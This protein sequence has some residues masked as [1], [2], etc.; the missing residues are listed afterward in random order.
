MYVERF[1]AANPD[2]REELNGRSG[3]GESGEFNMEEAHRRGGGGFNMEEEANRGTAEGQAAPGSTQAAQAPRGAPDAAAVDAAILEACKT[4]VQRE[5]QTALESNLTNTFHTEVWSEDNEESEDAVGVTG[6]LRLR[7]MQGAMIKETLSLSAD[8]KRA[9]ISVPGEGDEVSVRRFV[10]GRVD[11]QANWSAWMN[12]AVNIEGGQVQTSVGQ[13]G[14]P[15]FILRTHWYWDRWGPN[16][17]SFMELEIEMD[18][19]ARP[20]VNSVQREWM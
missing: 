3:S 8:A 2:V 14:A 15:K 17:E 16:T 7:N 1:L 20:V 12:L 6:T 13:D 19:N 9:G 11:G 4:S 10:T 5:L 18:E